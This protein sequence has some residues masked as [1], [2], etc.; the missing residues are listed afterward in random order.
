MNTGT[1][2]IKQP[3]K[4]MPAEVTSLCDAAASAWMQSPH[5]REISFY[6]HKKQYKSRR[7]DCRLLVETMDDEPVA[8]RYD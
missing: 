6:W 8:C 1:V 3:I 7:A 4:L 2:R 5:E